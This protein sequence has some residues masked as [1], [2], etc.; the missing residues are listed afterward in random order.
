MKRQHL[1]ASF[2]LH[3]HEVMAWGTHWFYSWLEGSN[4]SLHKHFN[5][6]WADDDVDLKLACQ[7]LL[8]KAWGS[9]LNI[10]LWKLVLLYIKKKLCND[11]TWDWYLA[12]A[13]F[14]I[15]S[16]SYRHH[17]F[18]SPSLFFLL[19]MLEIQKCLGV[20]KWSFKTNMKSLRCFPTQK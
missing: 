14:I 6:V 17:S 3:A 19:F 20:P 8:I 7:T 11:S 15:K 16:T 13:A 12:S 18:F 5:K 2:M 9:H 10:S 4:Q 1:Y